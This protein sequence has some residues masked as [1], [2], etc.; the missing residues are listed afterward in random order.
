[1]FMRFRRFSGWRGTEETCL[2]D[3]ALSSRQ[4]PA[5]S[6]P[7]IPIVQINDWRLGFER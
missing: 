4:N 5:L 6:R 3:E 1:M 2:F 7:P